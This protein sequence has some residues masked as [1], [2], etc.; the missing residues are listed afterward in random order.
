MF[1]EEFANMEVVCSVKKTKWRQLNIGG[2]QRNP[3][4]LVLEILNLV[5]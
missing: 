5:F 4:T 1:R 3:S 2:G